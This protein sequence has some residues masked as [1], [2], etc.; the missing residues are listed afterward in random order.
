MFIIVASKE[1]SA[2]FAR[3]VQCARRRQVS[4]TPL[5]TIRYGSS[6]VESRCIDIDERV[7]SL[8]AKL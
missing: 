2:E 6:Y 8:I 3:T 5:A 4:L 1:Q 7:H